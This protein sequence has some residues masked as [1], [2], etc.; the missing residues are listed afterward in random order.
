MKNHY[1]PDD[2]PESEWLTDD[3]YNDNEP[4]ESIIINGLSS[5][6][7]AFVGQVNKWKNMEYQLTQPQQT[8]ADIKVKETIMSLELK[9]TLNNIKRK[10]TGTT[11]LAA[12]LLNDYNK[13]IYIL[14]VSL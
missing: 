3:E 9:A 12:N 10:R 5:A 6:Q 2:S 13:V 8:V 11:A 14:I 4:R 1:A 7:T